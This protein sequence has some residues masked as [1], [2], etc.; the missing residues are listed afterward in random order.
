MKR[1][2][3]EVPRRGDKTET[4]RIDKVAQAVKP[5]FG[6]MAFKINCKRTFSLVRTLLEYKHSPRSK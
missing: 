6:K 4:S 1:I 2:E 5:S 3:L